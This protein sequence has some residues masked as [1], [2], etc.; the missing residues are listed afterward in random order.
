MKKAIC[1]ITLLIACAA[2]TLFAEEEEASKDTKDNAIIKAKIL[3]DTK[4]FINDEGMHKL[5]EV[6]AGI[7]LDWKYLLYTQNEKNILIGCGLNLLV[8]T[9]GNW[10]I[11][12][13]VGGIIGVVGIGGGY[14]IYAGGISA[15][16]S[17][18]YSSTSISP[19]IY[20]GAGFILAGYIIPNISVLFYCDNYNKKLK[21][22]LNLFAYAEENQSF[23]A[24]NR[25]AD[26]ESSDLIQLDLI[27]VKF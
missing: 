17:R 3:I 1:L 24:L 5:K 20:L 10:V 23:V 22:G 14:I 7:P 13:T 25:T 2:T 8:P 18:G 6:S 15:S 12:D 9:L 16:Y 21:Q 26:T 4:S 19:L 27:Q 11:G